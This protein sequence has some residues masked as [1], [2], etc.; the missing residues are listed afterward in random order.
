MN[1]KIRCFH[2]FTVFVVFITSSSG[3]LA[4]NY[5][6]TANGNA[7]SV[8]KYK[9]FYYTTI[10][11]TTGFA[12]KLTTTGTLTSVSV[13]PKRLKI[14]ASISGK[15]A[16][17]QLPSKGYYVVYIND[18]TKLFIFAD[19]PEVAVTNS[20]NVVTE[21]GIDN[22]AKTNVTNEVQEA[23]D[24]IANT[25]KTLLFPAG[26]YLV[27]AIRVPSNTKIYLQS[28]AVLKVPDGVNKKIDGFGPC[29]M[30]IR[31]ANN[32]EISGYGALDGNG[33]VHR[34]NMGDLGRSRV[35]IMINSNNV[36]LKGITLRDAGSWNSHVV[37]SQYVTFKNVKVLSDV[38]LSNT[39]GIDPDCSKHVLIENC[40]FYNG[41]DNIAIK[42]SDVIETG[43]PIQNTEDIVVKGSVF[44]TQKSSLKVGTE[45]LAIAMK[46]ITF[47]NNDVIEADRGMALYSYDGAVF[48]SINYIN[49]RF[50]KV[51]SDS[52]EC[53]FMFEIA[54]R[55]TSSNMGSMK[56]ILVK[57][58]QFYSTWPKGSRIS[59]YDATH[60]IQVRFD[61]NTMNG[62]V[63][64]TISKMK[65][66]SLSGF[67]DI[68]WGS[69]TD[70]AV[71]NTN[72]ISVYP[73]PTNGKLTLVGF[74]E[75]SCSKVVNLQ[76]TDIQGKTIF[77]KKLP[78]QS[79][80]E[81]IDIGNFPQ[82]IYYLKIISEDDIYIAKI[83]KN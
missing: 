78:A 62:S 73:N 19:E 55:T 1:R 71:L 32:I 7:V 11:T 17:F 75:L 72:N 10:P 18:A 22:L 76:I 68:T 8:I 34:A 64:N 21:L 65:I 2:L 80:S 69:A 81:T 30:L 74:A 45:T 38:S 46:N 51:F 57:D 52:K 14:T 70:I 61:N 41:D 39:D 54:P 4:Q 77:S 48:D 49:N 67:E 63:L 36:T 47:E 3:I 56:N 66:T 35:L 44:L 15:T 79:I 58:C 28:G 83:I 20:V 26:V 50:E 9:N 40:F 13:S 25:G 60:R 33:T 53:W 59:G 24:N 6:L 82:G 16:S 29:L 12:V 43:I 5:T 31:N 27:D 37:A 23:I 42:S